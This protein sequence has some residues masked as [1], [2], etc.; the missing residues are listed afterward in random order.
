MPL[1]ALLLAFPLLLVAAGLVANVVAGLLALDI[2]IPAYDHPV[3]A[4]WIAGAVVAATAALFVHRRPRRQ[5]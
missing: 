1:L 4:A 2:L 5:S 3:G